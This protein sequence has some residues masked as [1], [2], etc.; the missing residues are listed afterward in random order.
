MRKL[1]EKKEAEKKT[2]GGRGS[3][4]ARKRHLT[5]RERKREKEGKKARNHGESKINF[6]E[7]AKDDVKEQ[8]QE[9]KKAS[10]NTRETQEMLKN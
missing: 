5:K 10:L 8:M 4:A 7:S 1:R 3:G 6:E 9:D 2:E